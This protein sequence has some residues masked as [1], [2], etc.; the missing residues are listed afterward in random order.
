MKSKVVKISDDIIFSNDLPL[1]YI[2]GTCVI[3]SRDNY[4]KTISDLKKY[5][6]ILNSKFVA[7]ASF[8]KANRSSINSFRGIGFDKAIEILKT[9]KQKFKLPILV[10]IHLPDQAQKVKEVA[11]IIQIPAFLCRQ[12]DLVL[13][14]GETQKAVNV[15]KGQFLSPYEVEN[16]I[17]KIEST[18]NN[19]IIITERG[20]TFGYNNLVVDMRGFEIMKQFGYPIVFD[21]THSVQRPGGLA[22]KTGGDRQFILPLSKSAVAQGIAGV[23]F[24]THINPEKALSDGSNSLPLAEVKSY[25]SILNKLDKLVKSIM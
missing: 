22:F 2:A 20:T 19:K 14:A 17:K 9:V 3:E 13:A 8:D 16:I 24:E 18:K 5:F 11:D 6:E 12:T 7:K 10:D 4:L 23:F 21:A 15:K 25:V 1:V